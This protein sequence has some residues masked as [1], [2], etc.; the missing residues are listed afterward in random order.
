MAMDL[1]PEQ[2]Q[3]I[4]EHYIHRCD[5]CRHEWV[6]KMI[7]PKA[8]PRCKRYDWTEKVRSGKV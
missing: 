3:S 6:S 4:Q 7:K 1:D 5:R 8:C 2:A